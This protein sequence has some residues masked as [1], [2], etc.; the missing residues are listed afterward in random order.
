MA[1]QPSPDFESAHEQTVDEW[2]DERPRDLSRLQ[3]VTEYDVLKAYVPPTDPD[4]EL[5]EDFYGDV[6]DRTGVTPLW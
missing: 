1:E 5:E 6:F 4:R 3:D 2:R